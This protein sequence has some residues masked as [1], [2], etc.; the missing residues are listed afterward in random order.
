[1]S[2]AGVCRQNAGTAGYKPA[3]LVLVALLTAAGAEGRPGAAFKLT[4]G[5]RSRTAG[6]VWSGSVR[7][8][9]QVRSIQG[10]H[11]GA[12]DS[13]VPPNRW[14]V[15]LEAAG[16]AVSAKAVILNL[17]SPEEQPVEIGTRYGDFSFV[18]AE[19]P[20]GKA[21]AVPTFRGDVTIERVPAA[22]A[23]A[24][25]GYEDD[26]PA[27]LRT[28]GG[29]YWL[30][31]TAY[32]TRRRDGYR[33]TGGDEVM[34][35]RGVPSGSAGAQWEPP[36]SITPPGDHFR[37]ALAEDGRGRIWCV[38]GEQK[39]LE[40]GNFDLY[41]R[42][43]DGK[44]W[45]A[46]ER[47]T[48]NPFPDIFHRLVAD[49]KGD[50]YLVWMSYRP[51]PRR[52][53]PQS[54]SQ[55]GIAPAAQQPSLMGRAT[56][57][58]PLP[59]SDIF[60]RVFN[61]D[62]WGE[63]INLS[64]SPEDDWEPA[65][66]VDSSG[67]AWVAWD[68]YRSEA[69][70]PGTYDV[71]LRS[72]SASGLGPVRKVSATPFA[73]MRADVAVDG[74][75]RVWV[76]WE[77]GGLNWG[78]D[79]GYQNPLHRLW[80][81]PGGSRIYGPANYTA[82]TLYRRPRVAV[83]DG[84]QWKQPKARL[85]DATP[86]W[87][88]KNLYL[89]PRLG[90]DAR[91]QTWLFVR[92]QLMATGRNGGLM[93]DY[94]A[95]TLTGDAGTQRWLAPILLPGST[96]RED[97]VL[98]AAPA[99]DGIAVAV[100]GDGRHFPVPLPIKCDIST[101]AIDARGLRHAAPELEAFQPSA[102]G[103]YPITHP[104][105]ARQV[106]AIRAHRVTVGGRTY[107]I[108]RGDLHRHTEISMDGAIDGSLYDLYR[109][110]MDAAALDFVAVTDH[111]Y[112]AWLD[113]DE[114]ESKDTD[115][116]YQWWRTQ[117][118]ADLF[119]VPGRF[120]PLYG[121]E[122]SV[123]FPLGHRNIFHV[124]RGIFSYRVPKLFISERPE[125]IDRDAQGL[126]AYLR[127]TD[128]I[129]LPHSTGT[130]MGTDWR[131]RDDGLEPVAEL[132]SG[133]WGAFED[134]GQPRA[135]TKEASGGG[136]SGRAP[137]TNGLLWNALGA[138]YKIGFIASHDHWATHI[139]YANLLVPDRITTR[140]D[141]LDALRNRRTYASTDNIVLDFSAGDA[142]QGGEMQASQSP[143]FQIRVHGT[144]PILR[145]EIVKN[146]RIVFARGAGPESG[147]PRV[148]EFSFR[149]NEHFGDT[150]MG[151]SQEIQNWEAP[152][153]GIRPRPAEKTA[154]YYVRVTE[155]YSKELPERAGEIAWSSPIW[156]KQ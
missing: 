82:D 43:F 13:I 9:A 36:T 146:N 120:V 62:R 60:L 30:A 143:V 108:V 153:T 90:V 70:G 12:S 77:E 154:Y 81:R 113:T 125:L 3:L 104:D 11:L 1:M 124:H 50:L 135:A 18:P 117:K 14:N 148:V 2:G 38:Y 66:A 28:R 65:V 68:A 34:V 150:T 140:G 21:Y 51:G 101:L 22:D 119:Y 78:K 31:W 123:N 94:Y 149:D 25:P 141:I 118:S 41:A 32:R 35:S 75:D 103:T 54:P 121:Y 116:E 85:E 96:G 95:T 131:L 4:F 111:N 27:M 42:S 145:V 67:R 92:Q 20:Y 57:Q 142:M 79:T 91:G 112:G 8:P 5:A 138:G 109:Y 155:R 107:K 102:A 133:D 48:N 10:W 69:G 71:L 52:G 24:E 33:Y 87:M 15:A 97:T 40:T 126:W 100:A 88:V 7:D 147:D 105:E 58:S 134:L 49:R 128:G 17:L 129:G 80:L 86:A 115:N 59:Q 39:Q 89:S 84:G 132:Y 19:V 151:P 130:N 127:A 139:A 55:G 83:L 110:A 152:G 37:V 136:F 137:F 74:A 61:G 16:G 98:S 44:R 56:V 46:E 63:E 64:Q 99:E 72:Y 73:E 6:R 106:T 93:F 53:A 156:V 23:V 76:A 114:P 45:S 122:R 47:L 29:E 26:D 144:A